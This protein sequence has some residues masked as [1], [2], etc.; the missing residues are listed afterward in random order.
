MY[1]DALLLDI[2]FQSNSLNKCLIYIKNEQI[3]YNSTKY[4]L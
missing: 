4:N 1:I 3:K 2:T